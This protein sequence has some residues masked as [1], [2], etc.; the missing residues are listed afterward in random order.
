MQGR[1]LQIWR[2]AAFWKLENQDEKVREETGTSDGVEKLEPAG[3][4]NRGHIKVDGGH[5]VRHGDNEEGW[6]GQHGLE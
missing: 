5:L 4:E 6:A 3:A 2:T 1:A